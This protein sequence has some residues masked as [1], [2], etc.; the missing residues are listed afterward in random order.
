MEGG[1]QG[2]GPVVAPLSSLQSL[3]AL[4]SALRQQARPR[5]YIVLYVS[6]RRGCTGDL[7]FL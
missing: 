6:H 4:P 3:L 5:P 1:R 2:L 7:R